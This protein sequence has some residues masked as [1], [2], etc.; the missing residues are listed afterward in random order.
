MDMNK[1]LWKRRYILYICRNRKC[2]E[3]LVKFGREANPP[4]ER[5]TRRKKIDEGKGGSERAGET[6]LRREAY[7]GRVS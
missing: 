7:G 2:S 3:L 6:V 5:R 1:L 4:L